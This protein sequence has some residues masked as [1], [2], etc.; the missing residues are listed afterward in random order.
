MDF[1]YLKCDCLLI[2]DSGENAS[3]YV[4]GT[5]IGAQGKTEKWKNKVTFTCFQQIN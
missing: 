5:F 4:N 1:W 2:P 3:E